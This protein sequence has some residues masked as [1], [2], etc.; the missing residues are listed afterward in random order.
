MVQ[1][2]FFSSI[3]I[4]RRIAATSRPA[5]AISIEVADPLFELFMNAAWFS[6]LLAASAKN[7]ATASAGVPFN[8][9]LFEKAPNLPALQARVIAAFSGKEASV[10]DIGKFVVVETAFRET[11]YKDILKALERTG[12]MKIVNAAPGRKKG[13]FGDPQMVVRFD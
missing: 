13:T 9:V 7:S 6:I 3:T 12:Q 5:F 1:G 10:D 8:L 4:P 11:H 2:A